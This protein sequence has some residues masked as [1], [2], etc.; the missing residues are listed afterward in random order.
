M[1]H[2]ACWARCRC[3]WTGPRRYGDDAY[4]MAMSDWGDHRSA[5]HP[6]AVPVARRRRPWSRTRS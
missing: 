3:R 1:C 6:R 2:W 4:E 5:A